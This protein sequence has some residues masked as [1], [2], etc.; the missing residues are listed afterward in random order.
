MT[1]K[2]YTEKL[3]LVKSSLNEL[4][5]M[6]REILEQMFKSI[7][8]P[9]TKVEEAENLDRK[10]RQR[11]KDLL[12]LCTEIVTLQ[13][14]MATDI[15]LVLSAIRIK[16]DIERSVRDS[17]HIIR[18]KLGEKSTQDS[19]FFDTLGQIHDV[20]N[21]MIDILEESLRT[22]N[23]EILLELSNLDEVIDD[24]YDRANEHLRKQ[25]K[26]GGDVEANIDRL[27]A[28]RMIE[29]IAD[30]FCN[31]AEKLYYVHTAEIIRIA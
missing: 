24:Y 5:E 26:E 12:D 4:L 28:V 15:R 17:L 23:A 21:K 30:H 18:M 31:I 16:N 9:H 14:P 29:R 11:T 25:I 3:E 22:R 2:E 27:Q 7:E 10:V 1:R 19:V 13:Q 8:A 20:L 6:A